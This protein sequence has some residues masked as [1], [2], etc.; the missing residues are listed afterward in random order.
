MAASSRMM[1]R[2]GRRLSSILVGTSQKSSCCTDSLALKHVRSAESARHVST[3]LRYL[4]GFLG[5]PLPHVGDYAANVRKEGYSIRR[6]SAVTEPT[7]HSDIIE[8][9]K[10]D[11]EELEEYY[12]NYKKAHQ[13][14]D[15]DEAQKWFNQ[16]VW[17]ISRHAVSEELVLYPTLESLGQKGKDLANQSRTDHQV[18]KDFLEELQRTTDPDA[19]EQRMDKMMTDLREHI[20]KEESEDLVYLQEHSTQK[21]REN[22]GKMFG[23]GKLLAPTR[24]HASVPNNSAAVEA[25]LGLLLTPIDKLRDAFTAY[26]NKS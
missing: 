26:P 4:G 3:S 2:Q 7:T 11:H 9:I 24:P 18:T 23:L 16:F 22:A 10:H 19:F 25:A 5:R 1:L 13:R 14:G 15:E 6:M 20:K 17:E 21:S 12:S 8:R